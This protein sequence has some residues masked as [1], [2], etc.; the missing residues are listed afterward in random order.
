MSLRE[1]AVKGVVWSGIQNW[2]SS[3]LSVGVFLVL[4]RLLDAQAFG[5]VA[6]ASAFTGLMVIFL[7]QGFSRAIIQRSDLQPGH[8]DTAFWINIAGGVVLTGA[9]MALAGLVS[10]V[11]GEPQLTPVIRWLSVGFLA[12]AL[13]ATQEAVLQRRLNFK[14]LAMRSLVASLAGGVVGV[15]MAVSG[16]GLWSLVGQNLCAGL[17]GVVVL[18]RASEWRPGFNVSRKHI[19][20]PS[21]STYSGSN[22]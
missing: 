18:W 20:S 3:L 19:C 22:F 8:L 1:Q 17:V 13:S 7:R 4:A 12:S 9:G 15:G 10:S 6:L 14:G 21:D 11:Y 16:F 2:G 5:L